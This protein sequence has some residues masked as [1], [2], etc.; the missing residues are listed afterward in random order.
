VLTRVG[1]DRVIH[2]DATAI[3]F[4]EAIL[5]LAPD[6]RPEASPLPAAPTA[7][8]HRVVVRGPAGAGAT[9]IA[10][11]LAAAWSSRRAVA[12]V[13]LDDVAPSVAQRLALPIEPNIRTTIDAIEFGAGERGERE[14]GEGEFGPSEVDTAAEST[15]SGALRVVA[16]LPNPAAWAHVRAGEAE[17]LVR[18]IARDRDI[19]VIDIAAALEE[20]GPAARSRHALARMAV[21]ECDAVVAVGLATPVGL[22]RLV[23]WLADLHALDIEAPVHVVLNRAPSDAFRRR[24]LAAELERC[25]RGASTTVIPDD[26]TVARATW[27][28]A[29]VG[30]S[31]FRGALRQLAAALETTL[32]ARPQQSVPETAA[33][34]VS[35]S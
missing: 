35:A 23:V 1:A 20:V 9:E 11:G 25:Y 32:V 17:R 8:G 5:L 28:A 33:A 16:G 2:A 26:R 18:T 19:V 4:L 14:R 15:A 29:P 7:L 3:E 34:A 22:S 12:L 31:K 10:I 30:R 13:D 21:R 6:A 27:A 24:E